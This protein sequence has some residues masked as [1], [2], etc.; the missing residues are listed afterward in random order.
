M[1]GNVGSQCGQLYYKRERKRLI[2]ENFPCGFRA[3]LENCV[4]RIPPGLAGD[5]HFLEEG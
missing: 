5:D 2:S 4:V 3:L 1:G